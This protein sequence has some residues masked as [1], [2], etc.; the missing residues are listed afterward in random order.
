MLMPTTSI[1][2]NT[3]IDH[4]SEEADWLAAWG[5][6]DGGTSGKGKH[7]QSQDEVMVAMQG[8]GGKRHWKG[9][10]HNCGKLGH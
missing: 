4:I 9:K 3:L 6:C 1:D 8:D 2:P 7:S 5:K 10:C